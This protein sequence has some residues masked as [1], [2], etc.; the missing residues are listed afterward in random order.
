MVPS[1]R[2]RKHGKWVVSWMDNR[3]WFAVYLVL[4]L[5]MLGIEPGSSCLQKKRCYH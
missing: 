2:K 3:K 5:V 4:V 1:D